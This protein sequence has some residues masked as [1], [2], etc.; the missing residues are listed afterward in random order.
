LWSRYRV[1]AV[2]VSRQSSDR[3][4][5]GVGPR[6]FG[7][8]VFEARLAFSLAMDLTIHVDAH[9]PCVAGGVDTP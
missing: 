7:R 5:G 8:R 3:P 2:E 1:V 6:R 4:L 9:G